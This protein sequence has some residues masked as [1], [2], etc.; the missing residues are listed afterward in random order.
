MFPCL[1]YFIIMPNTHYF[2]WFLFYIFVSYGLNDVLLSFNW[3]IKYIFKKVWFFGV[4]FF[5]V[6]LIGV[7]FFGVWFF[8][9]WFFG[10]WFFG[11]WFFGVWF[12]GV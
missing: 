6:W 7:W 4:W 5:G 12:F 10:V 11:F 8:G 9:V 1:D 3:L 2:S